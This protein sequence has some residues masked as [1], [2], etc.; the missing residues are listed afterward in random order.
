M[1]PV[2]IV[3]ALCAAP[4]RGPCTD[5]E[6]RAATLLHD[7]LRGQGIDAWLEPEWVRPQWA[8]AAALGA[9]LAVAG[10]LVSVGAPVA[11]LV[12]AAV[13]ASGL[14][15][16]ATGRA[17]PLRWLF[18]RRATQ[19]VVVEPAA[20]D[21]I[22]LLVCAR[23]DAPRRGLVFGARLRRLAARL[24]G[25]PRTWLAL[26]ALIVTA[27]AALRVAG[28]DGGVL[29]AV[30][31]V[32]TVFLLLALAAAADV[33]LSGFSPGANDAAS[34][35]G[36]ALAVHAELLRSPPE[37]LSPGLIL[38]GAGEGDPLALRRLLR[39]DRRGA[40]DTVILDIGPAGAGRPAYATRHAQL[41]EA[42]ETAAEA[43]AATPLRRGAPALGRLPVLHVGAREG[44]LVARS[45]H[46]T[47][48]P[49]AVDAEAIDRVVDFA[50]A[51]VDAL[52]ARLSA[53]RR[54]SA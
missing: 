35:A 17:G 26:A 4:G 37:A 28:V 9:A 16:E 40:E 44:G 23:T 43:V 25:R 1:D 7:A 8:P 20:A 33:G 31:F 12:L 27:T 48:T 21:R 19:S 2:R 24:P 15:V 41:R 42:A 29:G 53:T 46:A 10:S 45:R 30:Q 50:L 6:R 32:P 47:D 13:A 14:A 38:H 54:T 3:S 22:A 52:D 5:A 34:A 39:R 36:A 51:A 11:G 18:P 49:D